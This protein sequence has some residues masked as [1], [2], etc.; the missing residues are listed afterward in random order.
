V[1]G[2]GGS[3][4][5][6]A[7]KQV[8][9]TLVAGDDVTC[10]YTNNFAAAP[11]LAS[12]TIVEQT[13]NDRDGTFGFTSTIPGATS[14]ALTTVASFASIR[15]TN[16]ANGS[17]TVT[18]ANLGTGWSLFS[19]TCT[20]P[21]A[22][23][24]VSARSATVTITGTVGITCTFTNAFDEGFIRQKTSETIRNFMTRRADLI[25]SEEPDRNRFIRRLTGSVWGAPAGGGIG[26]LAFSGSS[27]G[28]STQINF[29]T[30]LSAIMQTAHGAHDEVGPGSGAHRA[31]E[32][33]LNPDFDVWMESH[34]SHFRE[35]RLGFDRNG[36]FGITYLGA[37]YLFGPNVLMG[38]L[39]QIDQMS[40]NWNSAATSVSGNGWM[41]GPYASV[42]LGDNLF[43][44]GRLAWGESTNSVS[45][46]DTYRDNFDTQ[47]A[48]A[49]LNVTGNW[50]DDVFRIT[51]SIGV[52]YF[53]EHQ[54]DY[55]DSLGVYIPS[56]DVALGRLNFGPEFAYRFV[57]HNETVVEPQL[58]ATGVWDF[59]KDPTMSI[60]GLTVGVQD[61]HARLQAGVMVKDVNDLSL[62][63]TVSY[64]GIGDSSLKVYGTQ[65]SVNVPMSAAK[66][67]WV[68]PPAFRWTGIYV[69]AHAGLASADFRNQFIF[70]GDDAPGALGA[71]NAR[72]SLPAGGLFAGYNRQIGRFVLGGEAD[73]AL[74]RQTQTGQMTV[75]IDPL[76]A[77]DSFV[78]SNRIGA[79]GSLRA[80]FGYA[81]DTTLLYT[82]VGV[83]FGHIRTDITPNDNVDQ[84]LPAAIYSQTSMRAGWT[85]AIGLEQAF[86]P[87][88]FV[89]AEA[90]YSSF[91]GRAFDITDPALS[92]TSGPSTNRNS[93][94][95]TEGQLG[96]GY[97]F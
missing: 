64:D 18:E 5:T 63:W 62:R 85:T 27:Q 54:R 10:S 24:N 31:I 92:P 25:T 94:S 84:D 20:D 38:A 65:L 96:I 35:N 14:F 90:R 79:T 26:P 66:A 32:G 49:R 36:S 60:Q 4:A 42:R 1:S 61:L 30:S 29:S 95:L 71:S 9:I 47:R 44:D 17:Y 88:W 51:P 78:T 7:G 55:V 34:F 93:V 86:D 77:D 8:N 43:V 57:M 81:W 28:G 76:D 89:R 53:R 21:T 39:V 46:F 69:G 22:T 15:F 16:L 37:D 83:V 74:R 45:P 40:D 11:A 97:R 68:Q 87:H 56:Q 13:Q 73:V 41:A 59:V 58:S 6:P 12:L 3:T 72:Q 50:H 19:L 91:P 2:S 33:D 48:I 52:T 70:G 67:R 80:R 82:A 75:F 23:V